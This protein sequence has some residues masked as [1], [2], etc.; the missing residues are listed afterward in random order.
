MP[1]PDLHT[2]NG[3]LQEAV[4]CSPGSRMLTLSVRIV[5]DLSIDLQSSMTPSLIYSVGA[6]PCG[7]TGLARLCRRSPMSWSPTVHDVQVEVQFLLPPRP[8]IA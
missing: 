5:L 4:H 8:A 6:P 2:P 3:Y 1:M 7:P